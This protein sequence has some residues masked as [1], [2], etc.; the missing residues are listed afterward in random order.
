MLT[1]FGKLKS[2]LHHQ[3]AP[4]TS[5]R[6]VQLT[7]HQWSEIWVWLIWYH[8]YN[9]TDGATGVWPAV[10]PARQHGGGHIS[11]EVTSPVWPPANI[12]ELCGSLTWC[13]SRSYLSVDRRYVMRHSRQT[14]VFYLRHWKAAAESSATPGGK[15]WY[16]GLIWCLAEYQT[17]L[18]SVTAARPEVSVWWFLIIVINLVS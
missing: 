16:T 13:N 10:S 15:I 17:G 2:C 9:R 11:V 18:N 1:H 14:P 3:P 5:Q 12:W 7:L 6:S 4:T 8:V